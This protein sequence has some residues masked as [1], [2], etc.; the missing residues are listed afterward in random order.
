[1]KLATLRDGTPDGRL[2]VVSRDLRRAIGATN[3]AK[4]L[5]AALES[6]EKTELRLREL[7]RLLRQPSVLPR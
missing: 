4:S 2:V 7:H 1:M 3:V 5:L 6:W